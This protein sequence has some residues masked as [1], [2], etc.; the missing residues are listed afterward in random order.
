MNRRRRTFSSVADS[1]R[2][3]HRTVGEYVLRII[4]AA[5]AVLALAIAWHYATASANQ[6]SPAA[7]SAQPP[8]PQADLLLVA[9][10]W[11]GLRGAQVEALAESLRA[12][13]RLRVEVTVPA[14]LRPDMLRGHDV[15]LV[16][17]NVPLADP[18]PWSK[19]VRDAR[20]RALPLLW[21]GVGI[22]TVSDHLQLEVNSPGDPVGHAASGAEIEFNGS[23]FTAGGLLVSKAAPVQRVD[24]D[25]VLA[26]LH[27][28]NGGSRVLALARPDLVYVGFVPFYDLE[29]QMALPIAVS[30]LSPVLGEHEADPRVLLR[31]EDINGR[32]YGPGDTSFEATAD[33]L[34]SREVFMHLS[35]IP[36]VENAAGE[37]I[38]DIGAAE[39]VLELVNRHPQSVALVQHGYTHR[40]DDPRNAGLASGDAFEFFRDDDLT[41]GSGEAARLARQNILEG[42]EILARH[43]LRA[44]MYEAPHYVMSPSQE[45]AAMELFDVIHHPPLY[46]AGIYSDVL[47][48]WFTW[49]NGTAFVPSAL[50][51]VEAGNPD[52]VPWLLYR[53]E[54]LARVLPD[55]VAVIHYHPF[56]TGQ[57]DQQGDLARLVEGARALGFRFASTCA[58]INEPG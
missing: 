51:Y 32:D 35:L 50:G 3:W 46:Q 10:D 20:D 4:G 28:D 39:S 5:L 56:L 57:P 45:K 18:Q 22:E 31:L 37:V 42:R 12:Y 2:R 54:Q 44:P 29:P 19:L 43:G 15:L 48:P 1:R 27:G 13:Y 52:S 53:L 8:E 30:A 17:A 16:F 40:R 49:K 25:W 55:P 58:E 9:A 24:S 14:A 26:R 33:Y 11:R 41:M 34:R 6:G 23:R 38:A 36:V 47:R 7:C 21:I